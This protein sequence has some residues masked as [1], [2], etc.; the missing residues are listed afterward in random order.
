MERSPGPRSLLASS[1]ASTPEPMPASPVEISQSQLKMMLRLAAAIV[2]HEGSAYLPLLERLQR[3]YE[4][5]RQTDP[6]EFAR[7][8]LQELSK[9]AA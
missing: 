1:L 3:E 6:T 5:A 4:M 9:D 8:L 7:R 2:V